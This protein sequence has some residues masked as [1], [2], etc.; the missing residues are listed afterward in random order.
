M[1]AFRIA[2]Q[3]EKDRNRYKELIERYGSKIGKAVDLFSRIKS[4]DQAEEVTTVLFRQPEAQ[5]GQ[6]VGRGD[7]AG[8]LRLHPR[9]EEIL[10]R[11][12][13]ATGAREHDS[14]PR[15]LGVAQAGYQRVVD[16]GR[17]T[18]RAS[19]N[20]SSRRPRSAGWKRWATK[21]CHGPDIAAGEPGAERSD[22]NYRD[23]VLERRL[24]PGAR[25]AESESSPGRARRRL[26]QVH[27]CGCA[28]PD[29]AQPRRPSDAGG[30]RHG[31]ISPRGRLDRRRAGA[32]DRLRRSRQQRLAGG[33]PVHRRRGPA[34]A[35]AGHRAVRQ[36]PAAGGDR[37]EEPGRR[38]RHHLVGLPAAPDLPG[39]D[40]GA[41]RTTTQ[42]SSSPTACRRASARSARA[43][44]GSS[45]GARSTGAAMPAGDGRAAGAAGGRVRE[46]R[47]SSTWSGTSSSSRTRAAASSPRRWPATTSSMR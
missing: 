41:V 13:K 2:P 43:R 18:W 12:G 8:T 47:G 36:R 5:T 45:P 17:L 46:A 32:R 29:R 14:Q 15:T 4:T 20:R 24:R 40:P 27:A 19:P 16:R 42:R 37:A 39:A 6:T 7:R 10:A 21:S 22:P 9:L 34:H 44:S 26:S 33:Q 31:R 23:V 38:E 11:R 3:Y 30:R 35:A 28:V 25:A 1:N